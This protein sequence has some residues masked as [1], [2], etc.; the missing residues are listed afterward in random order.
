MS[1]VNGD[2]SSE[3]RFEDSEQPQTQVLV[4]AAAV[5]HSLPQDVVWIGY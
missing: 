1:D 4:L 2:G 3:L 5:F